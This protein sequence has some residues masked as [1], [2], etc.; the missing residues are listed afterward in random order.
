MALSIRIAPL[1]Q[2]EW[3]GQRCEDP[4]GEVAVQF[5]LVVRDFAALRTEA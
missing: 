5:A 2:S 1:E 3:R 4:E